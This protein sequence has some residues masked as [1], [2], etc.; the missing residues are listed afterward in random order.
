M[1]V[2]NLSS[3]DLF[4]INFVINTKAYI[5]FIEGIIQNLEKSKRIISINV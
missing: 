4:K 5:E 3:K 1:L 2:K